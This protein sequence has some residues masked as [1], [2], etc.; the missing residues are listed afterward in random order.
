[1]LFVLV[2]KI[3]I[4]KRVKN[5]LLI[6]MYNLNCDNYNITKDIDEDI[7]DF[8][9]RIED[10]QDSYRTLENDVD[11]LIEDIKGAIKNNEDPDVLSELKVLLDDAKDI[12][13]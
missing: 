13:Y 4:R 6:I 12:L 7:D 9:D 8:K 3:M 10:L 1:M 2:D 11:D 5:Q